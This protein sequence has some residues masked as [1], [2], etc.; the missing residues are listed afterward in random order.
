MNIVSK[1]EFNMRISKNYFYNIISEAYETNQSFKCGCG[2]EHFIGKEGVKV[3]K[4][5]DHF[6]FIVSCGNNFET[7]IEND[8]Q[9]RSQFSKISTKI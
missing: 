3:I 5:I 2:E 4:Q 9:L 8:L 1:R 7:L 6:E